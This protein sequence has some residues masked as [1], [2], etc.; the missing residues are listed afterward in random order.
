MTTTN[1]ELDL[2]NNESVSRGV[3]AQADGTFLALTFTKSKTFKTR[4]GAERW[5][6]RANGA[7]VLSVAARN[8]EM[9]RR[10]AMRAAVIPRM[11]KRPTCTADEHHANLDALET[12]AILRD[13]V[14]ALQDVS[15]QLGAAMFD[16]GRT[17]YHEVLEIDIEKARQAINRIESPRARFR[18]R[19]LVA[20]VQTAI[21]VAR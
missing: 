3:Y 5:F 4:K 10:E 20:A 8:R 16:A 12:K 19:M 15:R 9:F 13:D 1:T 7:V 17:G 6:A 21:K 2:G 18:A 14:A 11:K